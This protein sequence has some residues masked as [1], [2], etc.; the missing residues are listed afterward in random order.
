MLSAARA[1]YRQPF[2]A[3]LVGQEEGGRDVFGRRGGRQVDRFGHAAVAVPLKD[4]LHSDMMVRGDIARGHEQPTKIAGNL[5]EMLNR[6]MTSD[7]V[8]YRLERQSPG[9][10]LPEKFRMEAFQADIFHD[11]VHDAD[12]V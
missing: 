11:P 3:E 8:A 1:I 4:R 7:L 12:A 2:A 5:R 10:D 9:F 6:L